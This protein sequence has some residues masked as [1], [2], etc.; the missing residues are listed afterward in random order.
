LGGIGMS[1]WGALGPGTRIVALVAGGAVAAAAGYLVLQG[2]NPAEVA[3]P[4]EPALPAPDV[5]EET[6]TAPQ[7]AANP[8][9]APA[10]DLPGIDTWRVAPDGEAL[11]AGLAAPMAKVAVLVDGA[12]VS[13]GE[14]LASGEFVLQFTLPPNPAPSLLTLSMT[15][16]GKA[17]VISDEMVALGPIAGPADSQP[18]AVAQI[19]T[20]EDAKAEPAAT[21]AA[22][23][24][25]PASP[26]ALLL[27]DE[28]AVVLQQDIPADPS[29]TAQVMIDAITYT[30][31]GAV[32]VGGRGAAGQTVQI[33]LDN[34]KV[35]ATQVPTGGLWLATLGDAAPG[36]YTLRVDQLDASGKVTSR[37]ETPFLRETLDALASTAELPVAVAETPAPLAEP[38]PDPAPQA[39]AAVDTA[40][41][42]VPEVEPT[43]TPAEPELQTAAVEPAVLANA[44][45]EP[46]P[47]VSVTVQ[48][49]F[50]LWGIAQD[51]LGDGVL[52]V[53]V[54][55]AN[56]DKIKDPDLIY[57]G[58]I[59]SVPATP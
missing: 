36:I 47:P 54:F 1:A 7:P 20:S 43:V 3:A 23:A 52:Y 58:Q 12:M 40:P 50:T 53:Q 15:E 27:T 10:R 13:Q 8:A 46:P 37:F 25:V 30:P 22:A 19:A 49:G 38:S 21:D 55:A 17:L 5:S 59:L 18:A 28:G 11:V 24:D 51:S 31:A 44:A 35:A 2:A 9:E 26:E 14:A 16:P 32:Q 56:R 57:P 29:M 4:T 41:V 39:A 48:P 45:P 33:Y 6:A 42:P 34:A